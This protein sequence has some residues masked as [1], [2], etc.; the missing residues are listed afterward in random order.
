MLDRAH[1]S[2]HGVGLAPLSRAPRRWL[3]P[4]LASIAAT[5]ILAAGAALVAAPRRQAPAATTQP[6]G[7]TSLPAQT[8]YSAAPGQP[9]AFEICY[10]NGSWRPPEPDVQA[11]HLQASPRF[12]GI[13]PGRQPLERVHV[14]LGP[15]R[16]ASALDDFVQLSGLWTDPNA[17]SGA[18]PADLTGKAELW[19][20]DLRF[21]R[22]ELSGADLTA[23]VQAEG[24]GVEVVQIPIKPPAEAL[25][26]VDDRGAR[27]APDVN[28]RL[29]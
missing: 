20:L 9:V 19:A 13:D 29:R 16:S 8:F 23:V 27:L 2:L 18:C 10:F 11:A 1:A 3:A 14:E 21:S 26:V 22:L 12:R 15:Y 4:T 5:L 7:P 24:A 28:L 25:R 6:A 17:T